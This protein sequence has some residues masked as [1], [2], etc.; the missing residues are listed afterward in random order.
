MI[1][2]PSR[3]QMCKSSIA[4]LLILSGCAS[5]NIPP[6]Q[7]QASNPSVTYNY[8]G[9]QELLQANV[10]A[11]NFCSPYH[12]S[13]RTTSITTQQDGTKNVV[14]EC[15][16]VGNLPPQQLALN[17]NLT[18]NYRSDQELLDASR[19]AEV[20]CMNSGSPRTISTVSNNPDGTR[21]VTFQCA[22]R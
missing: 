11:M 14:F 22:P 21:T 20:Y 13:P 9:D 17:S 16:A 4:A 8:R 6:Q 12:A 7:V 1:P 10:N 19:N 15:V 5:P 2:M 3:S 18:Y